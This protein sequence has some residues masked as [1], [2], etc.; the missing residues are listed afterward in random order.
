MTNIQYARLPYLIPAAALIASFLVA[1]M[2]GKADTLSETFTLTG[3]YGAVDDPSGPITPFEGSTF[4]LVFTIPA[5]ETPSPWNGGTAVGYGVANVEYTDA[6]STVG[7]VNTVGE[8]ILFP[9]PCAPATCPA[10]SGGL[11]LDLNNL[12]VSGDYFAVNLGGPELFSDPPLSGLIPTG[13]YQLTQSGISRPVSYGLN[14]CD[15]SGA[16]LSGPPSLSITTIPEP[17]TL[18]CVAV[19]MGLLLLAR[20]L[21]MGIGSRSASPNSGTS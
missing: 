1:G 15:C 17:S 19:A 2:I 3:T 5:N 11:L 21:F 14:D 9:Y 8:V 20:T 7:T 4:T 13:S 10:L 18:S 16:S 6:G 12:Y